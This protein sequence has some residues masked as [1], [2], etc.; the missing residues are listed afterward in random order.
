MEIV[1]SSSHIQSPIN[2]LTRV[3][4]I[5]IVSTSN[6]NNL[7]IKKTHK[8]PTNAYKPSQSKLKP[9]LVTNVAKKV[10]LPDSIKSIQ[11]YMSSK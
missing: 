1:P 5:E 4:L 8:N 2:Y 11:N 9:L 6:Q 3:I 10:I 7:T